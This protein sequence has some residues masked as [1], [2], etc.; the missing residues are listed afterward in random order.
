MKNPD[1]HPAGTCG[2]AVRRGSSV[3]VW[4]DT[5]STAMAGTARNLNQAGTRARWARK[6][7]RAERAST[8]PKDA[9][10]KDA[11]ADGAAPAAET[12][13]SSR[14]TAARSTAARPRAARA[15]APAVARTGAKRHWLDWWSKSPPHVR[16]GSVGAVLVVVGGLGYVGLLA[17]ADA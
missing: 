3:P 11:G 14:V 4:C 13:R 7:P 2:V 1:G 15:N 5:G 9:E 17:R 8:E 12:S 6:A 10:P 16:Q